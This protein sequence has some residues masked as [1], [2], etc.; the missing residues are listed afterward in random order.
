MTEEVRNKLSEF[1]EARLEETRTFYAVIR[2]YFS[3][4]LTDLQLPTFHEF[5]E[6]LRGKR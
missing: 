1:F 4:R 6:V 3:E 2:D 5:E